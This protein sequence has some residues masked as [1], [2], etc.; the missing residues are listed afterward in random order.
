M[1]GIEHIFSESSEHS[2]YLRSWLKELVLSHSDQNGLI[3]EGVLQ[4]I[5]KGGGINKVGR[6]PWNIE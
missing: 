3:E 1:S 6:I 5:G 2:I 4:S